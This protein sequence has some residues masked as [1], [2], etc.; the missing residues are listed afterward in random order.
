MPRKAN[1]RDYENLAHEVQKYPCIYDKADQGHQEKDRV[2]NAWKE[3]DK[4]L[5]L[6]EGN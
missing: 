2:I 3:V 5:E 1:I 6:P 4:A